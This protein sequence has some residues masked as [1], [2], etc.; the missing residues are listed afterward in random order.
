[1]LIGEVV[2]AAVAVIAVGLDERA[3]GGLRP[4]TRLT[5]GDLIAQLYALRE[6]YLAEPGALDFNR[7]A[8]EHGKRAIAA[9]YAAARRE[10]GHPVAELTEAM[11][12]A[13]E[14]ATYV[15]ELYSQARVET[16]SGGLDWV[17]EPTVGLFHKVGD[18]IAMAAL[19]ELRRRALA[20]QVRFE[21]EGPEWARPLPTSWQKIL[22]GTRV[23]ELI[24][25]GVIAPDNVRWELL[26]HFAASLFNGKYDPEHPSF[27]RFARGIMASP[28]TPARL[29]DNPELRKAYP[30]KKLDSLMSDMESEALALSELLSARKA[31]R[32]RESSV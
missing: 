21:T 7:V 15:D 19:E 26:A 30:P 4:K 23:G 6:V 25:A 14:F 12:E 20:W 3:N 5:G 17:E 10:L 13:S 16:F 1:V 22:I 2:A 8:R 28:N 31:A 32:L 27:R 11:L 29:R 24:E 18:A 9:H